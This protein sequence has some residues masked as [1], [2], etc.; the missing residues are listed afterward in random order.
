MTDLRDTA[1]DAKR[2]Y[3]TTP[4]SCQC[5]ARR[6]SRR[7]PCKHMRAIRAAFDAALVDWHG[8]ALTEAETAR[9]MDEDKRWRGFAPW[10][11]RDVRPR[12]KGRAG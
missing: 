6:F 1:A 11:H 2:R 3:R 7:S 8:N 10:R 4:R 12:D 9:R 5:P